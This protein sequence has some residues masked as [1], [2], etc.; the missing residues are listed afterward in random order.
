MEAKR[1]AMPLGR[2][3]PVLRDIASP[4]IAVV[5]LRMDKEKPPCDWQSGM[6][7]SEHDARDRGNQSNPIRE[8]PEIAYEVMFLCRFGGKTLCR[9]SMM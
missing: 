1:Y 2:S 6:I 3:L 5:F 4:G 7:Y 9:I 8:Y